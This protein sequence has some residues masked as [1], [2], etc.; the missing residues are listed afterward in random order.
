MIS[1]PSPSYH[2]RVRTGLEEFADSPPAWARGRRLGLLCNQASVDVSFRPS[3]QRIAQSHPGQLRCLFS[4]QHGF[5][6]E[7]Q[8]NM[9][10]SPDE[11][12]PVLGIPVFSLYGVSRAPSP[13]ALSLIDLLLVDLQDVGCRVYTYIWT[14]HLAMEACARAGVAVAVLDRPN[15]IGGTAVEGNLVAEDCR[16]FVGL[17]PLPMRHG[18]TVGE[19]GAVFARVLDLEFHVARMAGWS[20]QMDFE[21]TGLPWVWPSPNM[22]WTATA[23]VYPGQVLWEG[24]NVSEGRGTTRPFEVFGAPFLD[25]GALKK[26]A[27][28]WRLPG[29]VLREQYFQPAFHKWAG[30]RCKGCQL[31]VTDARRYQPYL[32]SLALLSLVMRLH[33]GEF[34]WRKP[35]YEYEF[36]RRPADLIIGDRRV[37]RAVEAGAGPGELK[38]LW[39]D[40]LERFR[41]QRQELLLY[42]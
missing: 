38:G 1:A 27:Q 7:K 14:L 22:P 31:H 23:R 36:E 26:A 35:P 11:H 32:T 16:S 13:E 21:D 19:V 4:P 33:P 3:R 42:P 10:E 25:V 17:A 34:A 24:T 6:A 15:P 39:Q 18:M 12:D 30:L 9:V 8:D 40:E 29:F 20:R 37:R 28:R 41:E 2:A 5:H